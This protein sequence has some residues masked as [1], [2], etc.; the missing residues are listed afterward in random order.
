MSNRRKLTYG[1]RN[2]VAGLQHYK[3]A[4]TPSKSLRLIGQFACP[5]WSKVNDTG[6]FDESGYEIDHIIEYSKTK[7]NRLRNLQALCPS[8]HAVKT[9]K[10]R[11]KKFIDEHIKIREAVPM[12]IC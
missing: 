9:G 5:L 6:S 4:N 2:T 10:F 7:D 3:C 8:C 11:R 1:Q 12:D